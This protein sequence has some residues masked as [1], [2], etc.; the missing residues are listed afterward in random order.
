M[1]PKIVARLRTSTT[2]KNVIKFGAATPAAPYV[3][4]KLETVPMGRGIRIIAHRKAGE[5]SQ[6]EEY[7]FDELSTLIVGWSAD[8]RFKNHFTVMDTGEWG[9]IVTTNDDATI[10]MERLLYVPFMTS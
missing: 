2:I 6:L 9:E 8:D 3:V 4:V 1:L 10:S 5:D 7:I